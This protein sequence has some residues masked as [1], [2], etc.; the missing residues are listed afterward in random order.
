MLYGIFNWFTRSPRVYKCRLSR[1]CTASGFRKH[2][3]IQL[4]NRQ[5]RF[6]TENSLV[7]PKSAHKYSARTQHSTAKRH[8]F[9]RSSKDTNFASPPVRTVL[10][11]IIISC[12]R[13]GTAFFQ[14]Q[15]VGVKR[16]HCPRMRIWRNLG[17]VKESL[18][19]LARIG[20]IC[21]YFAHLVPWSWWAQGYVPMWIYTPHKDSSLLSVETK[22]KWAVIP[23]CIISIQARNLDFV[24]S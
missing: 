13:N 8:E 1:T 21:H 22:H 17:S 12:P 3:G 9:G 15:N 24:Y 14:V 5:R 19:N 4:P 2:E 10:W 18:E 23:L 7:G 6:R 20:E 16:F 11:L